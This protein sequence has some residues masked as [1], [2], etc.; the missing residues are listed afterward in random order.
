MN[1]QRI[2]LLTLLCGLGAAPAAAEDMW[3]KIGDFGTGEGD[4]YVQVGEDVSLQ[5]ASLV[6]YGKT[7]KVVGL[8]ETAKQVDSFK[9]SLSF[10]C[11]GDGDDASYDKVELVSKGFS[12]AFYLTELG[13][14][15]WEVSGFD[16]SK[17]GFFSINLGEEEPLW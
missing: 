3:P 9:G 1:A 2:S 10:T 5:G 13:V 7:G 17:S 11:E 16:G 6:F 14:G 12:Q 8:C 15:A 4:F